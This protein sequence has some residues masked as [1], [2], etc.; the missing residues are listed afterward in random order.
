MLK[1]IAIS[2]F[3][4][5]QTPVLLLDARSE[6]EYIQGH[7]PG[8]T[9]FPILNNEERKLVGTC[10]KQQGHKPA[11]IMGYK[12]VGPKFTD[13]LKYAYKHFDGQEIYIHC[14]R[15][16]L[17]S[18]I[19]ANLLSSAGFHVNLIKGGYKTYRN[20]VLTFLEQDFKFEVLGG[21][22]GSG[23]S[24]ILE[25][26]SLKGAQVL[27]IENLANHKGSAFG[28]L[29]LQ[30]QPSQEQFE[31]NVYQVL[32]KFGLNQPIWVEDESR[33][34][35]RLQIPTSIYK[36]IRN[37]F[38]HFLDY[39]FETRLAHIIEEYGVFPPAQLAEITAKLR[40]RMGDLNNRKA[41]DNINN[42]EVVAWAEEVLKYY[43]KQYLFGFGQREK[44]ASNKIEMKGVDLIAYLLN[45]K[46]AQ[47]NG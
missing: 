18:Q 40:K 11:V 45:I 26:L 46:K 2:D 38:V 5:I 44:D 22:T 27:D 9:S 43:D 15:G 37:G 8:A 1:L 34:I 41:I 13:Y 25:E 17:R 23:K 32:K 30:E 29:G 21:L 10:Y 35:G 36:G 3:L 33:L 7:I 4:S 19:M 16:G 14:W 42:G 12:L 28:A 31:N 47:P 24:E 20:E 6:G 39:S